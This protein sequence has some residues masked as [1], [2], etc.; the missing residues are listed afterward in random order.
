MV[1]KNLK[2]SAIRPAGYSFLIQQ[3]NLQVMTH[4]HVSEVGGSKHQKNIAADGRIREVFPHS[5]WP[6]NERLDHFEFAL[7]YDGINLEVL[8]GIFSQVDADKLTS[9]I[10]AKPQGQ[11]T[12]RIWYLYEWMTG[13]QLPIDN[14]TQGN[15]I[16]LLNKDKYYTTQ[17][18]RTQRQRI[19]DN[20][21][22]PS[23]FCPLVRKTETLLKFERAELSQRCR[24]ILADYRPEFLRRAI[25]FLYTK[26][27]KSS[28]AIEHITP[29]ASRTERF[30]SL[31]QVA[32]KDDFISKDALVDLQNRIVDPR[33]A[34]KDYRHNQNYVGETVAWQREKIHYISPQPQNLNDLMEGLILSHQKM[35]P[36]QIHPVVHAAVIAFGFV[37]MHPF[38]NGNGRIH[39]FLIHNILARR[40]FTPEG[41][42]FPISAAMLNDLESYDAALES[43]SKP[44]MQ[45]IDYTLDEEGQMTVNHQTALYYRYPD[46]TLMAEALFSF[47]QATIEKELVEELNFLENYDATKQAMQEIIDMPDQRID[48]FIRFCLQNNGVISTKKRQSH[49]SELTDDEIEKMQAAIQKAYH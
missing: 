4:W 27:T 12:R 48:F 16:D 30:A 45:R 33:Y 21:L 13:E 32:E 35:D 8:S 43:F 46:M 36:S 34:N 47:I 10:T 22:G 23:S 20:M 25:S 42:I 11:Y 28:F 9:W 1:K 40:G 2:P 7:K 5:Y 6:G 37:F 41:L 24:H 15:Y 38:D 18:K 49:F 26:E 17:G 19:R 31:L 3:F 29:N 44:L 39:R 14:L